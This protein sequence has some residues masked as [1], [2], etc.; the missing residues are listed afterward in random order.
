MPSMPKHIK[1]CLRKLLPLAN[2]RV[3]NVPTVCGF[4]LLTL[5]KIDF[6]SSNIPW[7]TTEGPWEL[8]LDTY[9][10]YSCLDFLKTNCHVVGFRVVRLYCNI[11][12][13]I[14]WIN[15][16]IRENFH[17]QPCA[18]PVQFLFKNALFL[19]IQ[20]LPWKWPFPSSGRPLRIKQGQEYEATYA[21]YE[22]YINILLWNTLVQQSKVRQRQCSKVGW[23]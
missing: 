19:P 9:L 22:R 16:V 1:E 23:N 13:I 18:Y 12:P 5:I 14:F 17:P 8:S 21:F 10:A 2:L 6:Q 15:P 20:H 7:K 11:P 4:G 3:Q